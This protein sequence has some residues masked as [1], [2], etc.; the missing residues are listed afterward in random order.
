MTEDLLSLNPTYLC[1]D[2]YIYMMCMLRDELIDLVLMIWPIKAPTCYPTPSF[3]GYHFCRKNDRARY[4]L[5]PQL[6]CFTAQSI[7][8]SEH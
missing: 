5:L 4:E 3:R 1:V 8:V 2:L 6:H 7:N